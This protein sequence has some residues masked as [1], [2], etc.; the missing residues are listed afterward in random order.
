MHDMARDAGGS[1]QKTEIPTIEHSH[2]AL[3]H[4][5]QIID[6]EHRDGP[7]F[8]SELSRCTTPFPLDAH[9]RYST[10]RAVKTGNF[11]LAQR[12]LYKMGGGRRSK[13][14]FGF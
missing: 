14:Y 13:H 5:F 10:A 9:E 2:R 12:N 3:T 7:A 8:Q 6:L 4:I 1:H 11:A